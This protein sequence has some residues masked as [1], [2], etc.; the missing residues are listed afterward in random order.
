M[1]VGAEKMGVK[2]KTGEEKQVML[3]KY[4]SNVGDFVEDLK[5]GAGVFTVGV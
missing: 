2:T 5:E 3:G 4:L 1:V